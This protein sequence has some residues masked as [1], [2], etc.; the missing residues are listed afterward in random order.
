MGAR[1]LVRPRLRTN[2]RPTPEPEAV[3]ADPIP[4]TVTAAL[5]DYVRCESESLEALRKLGRTYREL[6]GLSLATLP[7]GFVPGSRRR[8]FAALENALGTVPRWMA[9]RVRADGMEETP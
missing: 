5:A 6:N 9:R 3:H 7:R 4:G 2:E 1:R 8:L